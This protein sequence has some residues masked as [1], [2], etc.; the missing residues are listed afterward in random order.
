MPTFTSPGPARRAPRA[1]RRTSRA[2]L[3]APAP[4]PTRGCSHAL[5]SGHVPVPVPVP[6][7]AFWR[8][9]PAITSWPSMCEGL[10]D[11][12]AGRQFRVRT[13]RVVV[14]QD[15][16]A[17]QSEAEENPHP[18]PAPSDEL[19]EELVEELPGAGPCCRC[20]TRVTSLLGAP[21]GPPRGLSPRGGGARHY[22]FRASAA[23]DP[24]H[25]AAPCHRLHP[26]AGSF[27][28]GVAVVATGP[29]SLWRRTFAR[30]PF[31]T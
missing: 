4:G 18:R 9:R 13:D 23:V 21:I 10:V 3:R 8:R 26:S 22:C 30:S 28:G 17:P 5:P 15:H 6:V 1:R 31:R 29:H 20:Y 16:R 19:D 14:A 24:M 25:A 2:R 12:H 27:S 7:N 11:V